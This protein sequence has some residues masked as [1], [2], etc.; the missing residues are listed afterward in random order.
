MN[1]WALVEVCTRV[2]G[3]LV[4]YKFAF[5]MAQRK[6]VLLLF[7]LFIDCLESCS[8][9]KQLKSC[10]KSRIFFKIIF[11]SSIKVTTLKHKEKEKRLQ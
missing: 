3:V 9:L 4:L 5:L 7:F 10:L 11:D 1:C 8:F 6:N 2:S